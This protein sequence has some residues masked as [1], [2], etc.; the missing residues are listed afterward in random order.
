MIKQVMNA[1]TA[2]VRRLIENWRAVAVFLGLYLALLAVLF[3]F[4]TAREAT[5]GQ[6]LLTLVLGV[7][8]PALFFVLQAL[9]VTYVQGETTLSVML[10][11]AVREF[12]KLMIISLPVLLL[13]WLIIFLLSKLQTYVPVAPPPPPGQISPPKPPTP[14]QGILLTAFRFLLLY[15]A[16]PLAAVHLWIA[17]TREGLGAALKGIG[18]VLARA[19]TPRAVLI[20]VLGLVIFGLIPYLLLFARTPAKN[21]WVEIGL[22]GAR[23]VLA[24]ALI[25]FGWVITLGALA[26][27]TSG[28]AGRAEMKPEQV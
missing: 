4:F 10:R 23:L 7:V 1:L 20:Y 18:R 3:L 15:L 19:F 28:T 22:L 11:Q 14:W 5:I 24:L 9:G 6:L 13:A 16:L 2:A 26:E 27:L 12:W 17:T 25:L 21:P 8:A